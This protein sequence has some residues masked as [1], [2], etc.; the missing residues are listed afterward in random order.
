MQSPSRLDSKAGHESPQERRSI[1]AIV[2]ERVVRHL[3]R[4]GSSGWRRRARREPTKKPRGKG[5]YP[6]GKWARQLGA[7]RALQSA[8]GLNCGAARAEWSNVAIA[9]ACGVSHTFV[10]G[11]RSLETASSDSGSRTYRNK[12]GGVRKMKTAGKKSPAGASGEGRL[13]SGAIL[14]APGW[15]EARH[16]RPNAIG[17][18][19]FR[20]LVEVGQPGDVRFRSPLD[21]RDIWC[22]IITRLAAV[23]DAERPRLLALGEFKQKIGQPCVAMRRL[24]PLN[25]VATP[26]S[27]GLARDDDSGRSDIGKGQGAV[28]RHP[29]SVLSSF[30][31]VKQGW[32]PDGL[33]PAGQG[34]L[35]PGGDMAACEA[36]SGSTQKEPPSWRGGGQFL[37]RKSRGA[38]SGGSF[39]RGAQK[40][41]LDGD[42][43]GWQRSPRRG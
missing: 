19:L 16:G 5:T 14:G 2:S 43:L 31:S 6:R 3:E 1:A 11:L 15:G 9:K 17:R 38:V 18:R 42:L 8:C 39:C 26:T 30:S 35:S 28:A 21:R 7:K 36:P 25:R 12:H 27:A 24:E 32:S 40:C 29:A 22:G 37:C 20:P 13:R 34:D 41:P 33:G 23:I 10:N 4:T